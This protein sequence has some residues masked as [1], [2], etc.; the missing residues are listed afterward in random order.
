MKKYI[1]YNRTTSFVGK[2]NIGT[3]FSEQKRRELEAFS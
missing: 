1:H 3:W 2:N